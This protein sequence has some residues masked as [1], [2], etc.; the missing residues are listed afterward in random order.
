MF[1][2]CKETTKAVNYNGDCILINDSFYKVL[3][4]KPCQPKLWKV[5]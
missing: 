2:W 3:K 4:P 1:F 5:I